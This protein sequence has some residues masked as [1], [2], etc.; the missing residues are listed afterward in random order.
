MA[1]NEGDRLPAAQLLHLTENGPAPVDMASYTT[2][3]VAIFAL[4]GAFTGTCSTRH[5]PSFIDTAQ[6]FAAKGVDRIVCISVNDPFV[7]AAW[8]KDTGADAAGLIFLADAD[9]AFTRAMG[10]AFDMP[11]AGLHGRSK[12][13]AMLIEDG[14]I[15]ALQTEDEPG[16]FAK[17]SGEALL[18]RV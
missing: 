17:T 1:L 12:R 6:D 7:M 14:V 10:M 16:T 2:G 11:K 3:R 15:K 5:V 18:A 9:G 8:A 4:P 13:Y